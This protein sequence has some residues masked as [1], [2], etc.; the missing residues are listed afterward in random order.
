MFNFGKCTLLV[1][2]YRILSVLVHVTKSWAHSKSI[3]CWGRMSGGRLCCENWR[4]FYKIW[5]FFFHSIISGIYAR[6]FFQNG[7]I[8][9]SWYLLLRV[10]LRWICEKFISILLQI[11]L[12]IFSECYSKFLWHKISNENMLWI[13]IDM[14]WK[15][16]SNTHKNALVFFQF[17]DFKNIFLSMKYDYFK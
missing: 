2:Q 16:S 4:A 5:V 13:R 14:I 6:W 15:I 17:I 11:L 7:W 10:N 12:L 8:F 3:L 1:Q 9:Y